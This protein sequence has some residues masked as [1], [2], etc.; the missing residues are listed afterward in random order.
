MNIVLYDL[1]G[2]YP[3]CLGRETAGA[4]YETAASTRFTSRYQTSGTS[5][6]V[7]VDSAPAQE[8]THFS[9]DWKNPTTCSQCLHSPG[10]IKQYMI[11][12]QFYFLPLVLPFLKL[13]LTNILRLLWTLRFSPNFSFHK[14][15]SQQQRKE[16]KKTKKPHYSPSIFGNYYF[17]EIN[18]KQISLIFPTWLPPYSSFSQ[19]SGMSK[20]WHKGT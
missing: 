19:F 7:G 9:H 5:N 13:P 6:S 16:R 1:E 3:K 18:Y 2:E 11:N 15:D 10:H 4:Q 8:N 14:W 20:R 12:V 17:Y